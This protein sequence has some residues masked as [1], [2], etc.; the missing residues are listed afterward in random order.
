LPHHAVVETNARFSRDA[1]TPL[2]A[3]E[4]PPGL[5]S[6]IAR[7]VANQEMIVQAALTCDRDLAFQAVFGDPT[8]RLPLDE[9]W[10]MFNEMLY[11]NRDFLPE[12]KIA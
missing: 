9:S 3:G 6:L 12:W 1:V 7:H 10:R 8:N 4:L 11:A 5:H 2:A